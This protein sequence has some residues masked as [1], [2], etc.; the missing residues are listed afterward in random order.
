[1]ESE[2]ELK[3]RYVI[4]RFSSFKGRVKMKRILN[5]LLL[6]GGVIVLFTGCATAY[7][8]T[9]AHDY[10]AKDQY[11]EAIA[12]YTRVIELSPR[13][14]NAYKNRGLAYYAK[15]QHD[16]AIA[17]YNKALE[18]DPRLAPAY[19]N[20]GATYAAKGQYDKAISDLNRAL[21]INPRYAEAYLSK[22]LVYEE[23]VRIIEAV[24]AYK[25]FI[26]YA[27]PPQYAEFIEQA[28]QRI[29]ELEK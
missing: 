23:M 20:R 2:A 12:D 19:L 5:V 17:D 8:S 18:I 7:Y 21:E 14:V 3:V 22:A 24:E 28:K 13:S 29:R 6:V 16:E 25:D 4:G 10:Y 15:G 26:Q 11:D 27:A 9:R 1:M